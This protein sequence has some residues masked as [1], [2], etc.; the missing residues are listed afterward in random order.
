M[1]ADLF[2]SAVQWS[3]GSSKKASN[4]GYNASSQSDEEGDGLAEKPRQQS[5]QKQSIR[6]ALKDRR[7]VSDQGGP[8]SARL[9]ISND[10]EK[11]SSIDRQKP[12]LPSRRSFKK[13]DITVLPTS[14]QGSFSQIDT[15]TSRNAPNYKSRLSFRR[16]ESS[17]SVSRAEGGGTIRSS[18]APIKSRLNA[19]GTSLARSNTAQDMQTLRGTDTSEYGQED[20]QSSVSRTNGTWTN[21]L[22][23]RHREGAKGREYLDGAEPESLLSSHT[24]EISNES[25][26][27]HEDDL[28]VTHHSPIS[29]VPDLPWHTENHEQE[30]LDQKKSA[31]A[32]VEGMHHQE[33]ET[34]KAWEHFDSRRDSLGIVASHLTG[35]THSSSTHDNPFGTDG[36]LSPASTGNYRSLSPFRKDRMGSV[37]EVIEGREGG[38]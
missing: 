33:H 23:N 27:M 22:K 5:P 3:S 4:N 29:A 28:I 26:L 20:R 31:G 10:D 24:Q 30:S 14:D 37:G 18:M 7:N 17:S 9:A 19:I 1:S 34:V 16:A 15:E 38:P 21:T 8:S 36:E 35:N 25:N 6:E 2:F 12:A 32:G 13:E 11:R